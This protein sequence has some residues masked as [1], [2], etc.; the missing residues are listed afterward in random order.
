MGRNYGDFI[1][2]SQL[3]RVTSAQKADFLSDMIDVLDKGEWGKGHHISEDGSMCI[4]GAAV[5][6]INEKQKGRD[7]L[8]DLL[9]GP[10]EIC[11]IGNATVNLLR[12]MLAIEM[13]VKRVERRPGVWEYLASENPIPMFNDADDTTKE[14]VLAKLRAAVEEIRVLDGEPATVVEPVFVQ[15]VVPETA[16]EWDNDVF[17]TWSSNKAAG[18]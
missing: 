15:P 2:Q 13:G 10:S 16:P 5:R 1:S 8:S 18:A 7:I 3:S 14:K 9:D 12:D 11:I 6:I 4:E 17:S